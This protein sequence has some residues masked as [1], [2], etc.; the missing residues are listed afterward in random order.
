MLADVPCWTTRSVIRAR[1]LWP[2]YTGGLTFRS[3]N[4]VHYRVS[5][6]GNHT[7]FEGT[8]GRPQKKWW[9]AG[10]GRER[11]IF[12]WRAELAQR[13]DDDRFTWQFQRGSRRD[14]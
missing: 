3:P 9:P 14:L 4:G 12:W 11:H 2:R 5:H 13:R 6:D 7:R 1:T 8:K 10:P